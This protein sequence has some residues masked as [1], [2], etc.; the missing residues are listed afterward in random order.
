[1]GHVLPRLR[2]VPVLRVRGN[3]DDDTGREVVLLALARDRP[4]ALGDE[5][6]LIGRVHVPAVARAVPEEHLGEPQVL[7]VLAADRGERLDV[8]GEDLRDAAGPISRIDLYH[9]HDH[10]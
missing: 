5:K 4:L 8:A 3:E 2:A 7:A 10:R 9:S 1:M 6:D